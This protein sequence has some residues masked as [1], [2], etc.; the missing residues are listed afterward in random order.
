M[1]LDLGEYEAVREH[2]TRFLVSPGHVW[3]PDVEHTVEQ[4]ERY[5]VLQKTGVAGEVAADRNPRDR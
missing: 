2:A 5:W 3:T 4:H 1:Q